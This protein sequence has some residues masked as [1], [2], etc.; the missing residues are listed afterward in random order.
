MEPRA[1]SRSASVSGVAPLRVSGSL[2]L[3]DT[4]AGLRLLARTLPI[5]IVH[6][7]RYWV[8]VLPLS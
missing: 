4:D 5:R 6:R 1:I 7:T 3:S 2:T 8:T